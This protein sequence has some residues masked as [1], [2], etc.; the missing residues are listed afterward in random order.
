MMPPETQPHSQDQQ[1][2]RHLAAQRLT[3]R[4]EAFQIPMGPRDDGPEGDEL[5]SVSEGEEDESAEEQGKDERSPQTLHRAYQA[6]LRRFR[7]KKKR[8]MQER[9]AEFK[10][11]DELPQSESAILAQV[12]A[13]LFRLLNGIGAGSLVGVIVPLVLMHIQL[14]GGN[15]FGMKSIPKLSIWEMIGLGVMD[16]LV[17]AAILTIFV[18]LGIIIIG[19]VDPVLLLDIGFTLF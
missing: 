19:F 6:Y 1:R 12:R 3:L 15:M 17:F 10:G 2:A 9:L 7:P 8:T 14:V 5:D 18:I 11:P 13:W 4:R 16:L